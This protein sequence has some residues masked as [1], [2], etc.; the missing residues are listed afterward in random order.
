V[1]HIGHDIKKSA[2]FLPTVVRHSE[3]PT[4]PSTDK[5]FVDF[6][7]FLDNRGF[8]V[9]IGNAMSS[10]AVVVSAETVKIVILIS[11]ASITADRG[12]GMTDLLDI[13]QRMF[14]T[15]E[16]LLQHQPSILLGVTGYP[17]DYRLQGE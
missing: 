8:E 5:S 16:Q 4:D 6:P 13:L 2:T 14:G 15:E 3:D 17:R 10:R 11:Y 9:N 7:G 1:A 12:R